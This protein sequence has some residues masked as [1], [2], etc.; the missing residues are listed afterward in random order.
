MGY[1][2]RTL[3]HFI[4]YAIAVDYADNLRAVGYFFKP[5]MVLIPKLAAIDAYMPH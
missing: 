1:V 3:L 2:G 5:R 4:L